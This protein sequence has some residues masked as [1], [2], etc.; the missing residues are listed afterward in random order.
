LADE[1]RT[2]TGIVQFPPREGEAGGK[3]VRNITVRQVGFGPT[4]VRVSATL[5]PS[6]AHVP[7][8]EGDVVMLDGKYKSN[9]GAKDDGTPVK[10]HNLSV[11]R[12][13]VLGKADAGKKVDTVNGESDE[14]DT[15]DIPF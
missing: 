14:A 15:D 7:V 11:T 4:A 13:A 10:Y 2:V 6:H 3:P 9:S 12:I 1:F 5:W 8:E